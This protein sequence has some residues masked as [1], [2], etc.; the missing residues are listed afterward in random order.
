MT[1]TNGL[2][3]MMFCAACLMNAA[4]AQT[5][6]SPVLL[7]DGKPLDLKKVT[8]PMCTE[9]ECG[10]KTTIKTLKPKDICIYAKCI[11]LESAKIKE[12]LP[13]DAEHWR[14]FPDN[15]MQLFKGENPLLSSKVAAAAPLVKAEKTIVGESPVL[16]QTDKNGQVLKYWVRVSK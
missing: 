16:V 6:I 7:K 11:P 3:L 12:V 2:A 4:I 10:P 9:N 8:F 1:K 15:T 14:L 5:L 13:A